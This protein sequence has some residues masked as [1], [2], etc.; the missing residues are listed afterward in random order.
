M[1]EKQQEILQDWLEVQKQ[2]WQSLLNHEDASPGDWTELTNACR[3]LAEQHLPPQNSALAES[4][5][6]QAKEFSRYGEHLLKVLKDPDNAPKIEEIVF[7]FATHLQ[8]RAGSALFKQWGLPDHLIQFLSNMDISPQTM[9]GFPF[10]QE[11]IKNS[12]NHLKDGLQEAE[13]RY[14]EFRDALSQYIEIQ[15]EI[16]HDCCHQLIKTLKEGDKIDSLSDLHSLWV[17]HYED[18]Y[19]K[20]LHTSVYQSSYGR[21]S[22]ASLRLKKLSREYWEKEY[23][24]L[25]LVPIKDYTQLLQR[26]HQLQKTVKK[27]TQHIEQLKDQLMQE[28]NNYSQRL[29]QLENHIQSLL[30]KDTQPLTSCASNK[31]RH[32]KQD[33]VKK[34][35]ENRSQ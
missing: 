2:Y 26:H 33:T 3:Q 1:D 14:R 27:N 10:L 15:K 17:N 35:N 20:H 24:D 32:K 16:N 30:N 22:N 21:L 12:Q 18:S 4:M 23:R 7:E 25:G 34:I 6:F 19:R 28:K 8:D 5:T 31:R 13:Q 9:P 11:G 29:Q